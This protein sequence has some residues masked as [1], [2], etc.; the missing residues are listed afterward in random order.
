MT[1]MISKGT[2]KYTARTFIKDVVI[3]KSNV[4]RKTMHR[5]VFLEANVGTVQV[6]SSNS[7]TKL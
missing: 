1:K 5:G 7:R 2:Y 6:K 3:A 4:E